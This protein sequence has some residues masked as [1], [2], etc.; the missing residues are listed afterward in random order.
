MLCESSAIFIAFIRLLPSVDPQVLCEVAFAVDLL[1]LP[2]LIRL[3]SLMNYKMLKKVWAL[4]EGIPPLGTL[5][6]LHSRVT[7][8]T[9]SK[10]ALL[11]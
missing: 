7:P 1:T 3:L 4:A 10:E 5:I 6:R 11:A 8:L 2:V 9:S